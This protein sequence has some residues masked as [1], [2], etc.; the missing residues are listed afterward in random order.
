MKVAAAFWG[1]TVSLKGWIELSL[2]SGP[3]GLWVKDKTPHPTACEAPASS[4]VVT[5]WEPAGVRQG[6]A[7]AGT[8]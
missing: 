7:G 4:R 8:A 1:S 6:P 3:L 5:P 2:G